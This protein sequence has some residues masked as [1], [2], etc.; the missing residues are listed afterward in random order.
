MTIKTTRFVRKPFYIE[1][2]QVTKDNID[3][4]RAW[5]GGAICASEDGKTEYIKVDVYRPVNER[6]SRAFIGDWVLKADSGFKVFTDRAFKNTFDQDDSAELDP[7]SEALAM[8]GAEL[9]S[10]YPGEEPAT[11]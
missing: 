1:A 8:G 9:E 10:A 4:V 6:Q 7:E 2:V 5:C 11:G 3:G